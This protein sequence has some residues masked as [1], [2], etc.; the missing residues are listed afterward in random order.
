MV[1]PL[2]HNY[3]R[4]FHCKE[5]VKRPSLFK[6]ITSKIIGREP[7]GSDSEIRLRGE[8]ICPKCGKSNGIIRY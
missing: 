7:N 6:T 4:C 2:P 5:E 8:E 3:F 1:V